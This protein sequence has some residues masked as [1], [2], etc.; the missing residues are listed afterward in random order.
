MRQ[1]TEHTGKFS[2]REHEAP[3]PVL[4]RTRTHQ[5]EPGMTCEYLCIPDERWVV[6][7]V[8]GF[9]ARAHR[10]RGDDVVV[11]S[12]PVDALLPVIEV[13][14]VRADTIVR[15]G[16]T[17]AV[18]A[19]EIAETKT[20]RAKTPKPPRDP[21]APLDDIALRLK[22]A[23]TLDDLWK[24]AFKLGLPK[25]TR[26][27]LAHLNPGLQR[28][29]IGNRLRALRKAKE[30]PSEPV[31]DVSSYQHSSAPNQ[32]HGKVKKVGK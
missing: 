19:K 30:R 31:A 9:W 27:K 7:E 12:F 28:M 11:Q 23:D 4:T 22:E 32:A 5:L 8:R 21:N 29:G 13:Q 26:A 14:R 16:V 1:K 20:A 2:G 17:K 25:D 3:M 18:M 24:L 15:V 10:G 6:D